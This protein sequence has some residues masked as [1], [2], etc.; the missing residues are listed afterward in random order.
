MLITQ[1]SVY[2]VQADA[3]GIS[4]L[5]QEFWSYWLS[6]LACRMFYAFK[7]Y[8]VIRQKAP[9]TVLLVFGD[10]FRWRMSYEQLPS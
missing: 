3:A 6:S 8:Q 2:A 7:Q 9:V 1:V 4:F 5:V 10:L